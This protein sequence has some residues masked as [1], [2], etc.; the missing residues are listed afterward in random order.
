[1]ARGEYGR[2]DNRPSNA[3]VHE[4]LTLYPL[5]PSVIAAK[6]D[7]DPRLRDDSIIQQ[8]SDA[9][10]WI[11]FEGRRHPPRLIRDGYRQG[12]EFYYWDDL[13]YAG[14]LSGSRGIAIVRN[15]RVIDTFMTIIS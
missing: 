8:G 4:G 11:D 12:D 13:G 7:L 3:I 15:G 2:N 6:P 9:P 10:G 1:M 5:T 14:P